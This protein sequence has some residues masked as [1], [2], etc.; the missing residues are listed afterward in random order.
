MKYYL[1]SVFIAVV[2]VFISYNSVPHDSFLFV[3][4]EYLHL[5][6]CHTYNDMFAV[7]FRDFGTSNLSLFSLRFF[8]LLYF[9]TAYSIVSSVYWVQVILLLLKFILLTTVPY[10]GF[11]RLSKILSP[12]QDLL[13]IYLVSLFYALNTF[14]VI[15]LNG[16]A[17][18]L[19][20]LISF[21]LAPL[22]FY[23]VYKVLFTKSPLYMFAGTVLVLY[24]MSFYLVFLVVFFLFV[25][26]Y[27][28]L[29]L[30]PSPRPPVLPI[31][32]RG[33][34]LS[35]L[36]LPYLLLYALV[37][38]STI[39]VPSNTASSSGGDTYNSLKGGF[40]TPLLMLYSWGIYNI[41]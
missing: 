16:N 29:Q 41:W 38:Y 32:K 4:D 3:H 18:Q 8:D 34:I 23:L 9:L 40:V 5:D 39:I 1:F 19:T 14:T 31:L 2:L 26:V 7:M 36:Y 25:G 33:L 24:A 21:V 22:A 20:P 37:L 15:Y 28:L 35:A 13:V 17:F 30:L 11:K 27:A 6:F 12:K 10:F